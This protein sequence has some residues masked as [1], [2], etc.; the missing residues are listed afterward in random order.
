MGGIEGIIVAVMLIPLL[1]LYFLPTIV[2]RHQRHHATASIF[3]LNL[4]LGWTLIMWIVCF[5]WASSA[6]PPQPV[7][8]VAPS[9]STPT[10]PGSFCSSCGACNS[11]GTF[12]SSCGARLA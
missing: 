1:A 12:C 4:V 9:P 7:T 11:G 5:I 3:L 8:A 2:A 10:A 6:R